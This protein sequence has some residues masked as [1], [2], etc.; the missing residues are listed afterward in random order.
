MLTPLSAMLVDSYKTLKQRA[1]DTYRDKG[2]KFFAYAY[3]VGTQEE[4]KAI[5]DILHK[6]HYNAT[7][8]CYAW[9]LGFDGG[10]TRANDD[11]EPSSTAGKP[12]LGA[13]LSAE[14]TNVLVVVVR[15]FG[16]TKLGVPGLIDAYRSSAEV[17]LE[18]ENIVEKDVEAIYSVEFSY[19]QMNDVMGAVKEYGARIVEQNFDNLSTMTLSIKKS[20]Q[21]G[22]EKRTES[23]KREFKEYR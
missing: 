7:H 15:Y 5:L 4:I 13:I 14:L 12:I 18:S 21:G 10:Q 6:E 17:V 9:R 2:S 1:E 19:I 3:P 22:F 23:L 8:C 16:G 20:L 11:G